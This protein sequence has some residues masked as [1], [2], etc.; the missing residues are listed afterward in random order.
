MARNKNYSEQIGMKKILFVLIV[1]AIAVSFI[2]GENWGE[3][4]G[5]KI[6]KDRCLRDTCDSA[7]KDCNIYY[8]VTLMNKDEIDALCQDK[9]YRWGW[10]GCSLDVGYTCYKKNSDGSVNND[11]FPAKDL[12]KISGERRPNEEN[13]DVCNLTI[14]WVWKNM[15]PLNYTPNLTNITYIPL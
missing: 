3:I 4:V 14:E 6:G 12:I 9:G 13:K 8:N 2:A 5:E 1:F 10:F 15:T 7:I 11:C